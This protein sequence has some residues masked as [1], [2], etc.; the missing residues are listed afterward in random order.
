MLHEESRP[1]ADKTDEE[2][3]AISQWLGRHLE[4]L[5]GQRAAIQAEQRMRFGGLRPVRR[6]FDTPTTTSNRL[7]LDYFTRKTTMAWTLTEGDYAE[8]SRRYA[9][10]V[11]WVSV[12]VGVLLL[13]AAGAAAVL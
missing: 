10:R 13:G 4:D 3:A 2:L 12:A 6:F 8:R 5:E 11:A 7:S 1:Y 9:M